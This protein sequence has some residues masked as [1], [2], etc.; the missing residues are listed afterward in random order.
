MNAFPDPNVISSAV[1][2]LLFVIFFTV[3]PKA[4]VQVDSGFGGVIF[5]GGKLQSELLNPGYS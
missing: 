3:L 2:A 1:F 5:R 4:I